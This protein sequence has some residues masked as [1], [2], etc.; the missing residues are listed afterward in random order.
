[1]GPEE[2]KRALY[3]LRC[4]LMMGKFPPQFHFISKTKN[5]MGETCIKGVFVNEGLL[6]LI[7]S[8]LLIF[9]GRCASDKDNKSHAQELW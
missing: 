4:C 8:G 5:L 1:M 2:K 9:L 3:Y 7:L 6:T